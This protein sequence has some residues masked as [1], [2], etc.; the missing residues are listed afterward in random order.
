MIKEDPLKALQIEE[1]REKKE[2]K[3]LIPEAPTLKLKAKLND[4]LS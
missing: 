3:Q 2:P 1:K 4:K